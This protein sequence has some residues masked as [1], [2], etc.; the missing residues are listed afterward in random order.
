[1]ALN[2]FIEEYNEDGFVGTVKSVFVRLTGF[3]TMVA[4]AKRQSEINLEM[5]EGDDFVNNSNLFEFLSTNGFLIDVDYETFND[6]VKNYY[7]NW[8]LENDEDS[9]LQYVCDH[10]LTDVENRGGQ[11]WL[12]L[13]NREELADFFK[14]YNRDT[15][16][17]DL[18]KAIFNED[19]F[20]ERF[21]DTTDDVYRDV[22]NDLNDEN[23]NR[24][25]NYIV[26]NIG[27]QELSLEDYDDELFT[28]FSEEQGTEGFFT[29]TSENVMEL[30]SDERAMNELLDGELID[31]KSELDSVH[32]SAYNNA[33]E[34]ECYNLVYNGLEE[35]FTSKIVEEPVGSDN[36]KY[37]NYIRIRDF[38]SNVYSFVSDRQGYSYND[39]LLEYFGTYTGMMGILFDEGTY[40]AIDFRIPEYADWDDIRKN[41][42]EYFSDYI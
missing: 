33:Y 20:F 28:Q 22:I 27:N 30:I 17:K 26:K 36:A 11:Y 18:A 14:E 1:M 31:L 19:D 2:N 16:P 24:L 29:I 15:S 9:A 8:W 37:R 25:A 38:K 41:I 7:L 13:R 5:L 4:K 6:D 39:S 35:F 32:N 12:Y 3:L 42:N 21:W 23:K 34:S 10:L 40:E